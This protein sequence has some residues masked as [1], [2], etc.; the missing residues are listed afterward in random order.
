MYKKRL[1]KNKEAPPHK[2][3]SKHENW[4]IRMEKMDNTKII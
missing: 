3:F 1:F 2:V 4:L